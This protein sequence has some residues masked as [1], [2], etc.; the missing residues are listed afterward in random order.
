MI[1]NGV[2]LTI[3]L[4]FVAIALG[5]V[6]ATLMSALR[7]LAG[8][9]AG[10]IVDAYVELMRNT[11]FLVQLF[12]IFFGLPQIGIRMNGLEASM[13]AMTLNLAAYA[14]EIIR[15]GVD[16]IHKSQIEAG[17]ALAM[18]RRQVFQYV[19]LQPAFARVWP[20]LS[21]QF[22]LMM[23]AS[24]ICSFV[25]VQELSGTAA[26]I[27]QDTF[28]SFETYIIVTVIYLVLA[29]SLKLFLN[30]L[31]RRIFPQ[32]SGLARVAEAHGEAA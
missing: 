30:W 7:S 12:M 6:L 21:S 17:L 5:L 3:A 8:S 10:Y 24:S 18:S 2:M 32:V 16:S 11:P 31:G 25:S 29:L 28:R 4:S 23:L 1:L 14:T 19:V 20:A 26:I 15:A 9:W 27:E 13:L 22:V